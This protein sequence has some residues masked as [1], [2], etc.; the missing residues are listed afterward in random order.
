M[1][2]ENQAFMLRHE[3]V[4]DRRTWIYYLI[5][6]EAVLEKWSEYLEVRPDKQFYAVLNKYVDGYVNS[7][8]LPPM[9]IAPAVMNIADDFLAGRDIQIRAGDYIAIQNFIR[10]KR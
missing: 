5:I 2:I 7:G 4:L 6:R 1:S 10:G 3:T 8:E 9:E